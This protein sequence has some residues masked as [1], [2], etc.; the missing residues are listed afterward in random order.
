MTLKI[1]LVG[2]G[3]FSKLHADIL[4]KMEGVTV[5]S[6]CGTTKEKAV[7]M[8]KKF[9]DANGYGDFNDM[10]DADQL[11]AVYI[12]I[13]PMAHGAIEKELIRRRIP[14]FV[15]KPL[16]ADQSIV[17][18]IVTNLKETS[19]ITSVGYHFRYKQSVQRLIETLKNKQI[20]MVTGHWMGTMPE[21]AWWRKQE[22]S[23]GQF[24]EQTTHI[25]DLLRYVAGEVD[26]V[27]AS[28]ADL[29]IDKKFDGVTV[30]DVGSVTMKLKSG[31]IVSLTNTCIL[32]NGMERV[33][34]S[35]Y[36]DQGMLDWQPDHMSITEKSGTRVVK[37]DSDNPYV[38]ENEAFI[39]AVRTGETFG[40][41]SNYFDAY[42][43]HKVTLA[44]LESSRTGLPVKLNQK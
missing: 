29:V 33:G 43:T 5:Q 6:I 17:D 22:G 4:S 7:N 38:K 40:I 36:T 11:D 34:M 9:R 1:G 41:L 13:P 2:T 42:E 39:H 31:I 35:V 10:L 27:Y 20:G 25:V 3:S 14:F 24:I 15:E 23:G 18:S 12:C 44:A 26:E 32:P 16:G 8:A 30:A 28:Y 37:V 21:V 19:L